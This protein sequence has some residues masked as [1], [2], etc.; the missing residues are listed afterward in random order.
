M[1]VFHNS[2]SRY[3]VVFYRVHVYQYLCGGQSRTGKKK[4]IRKKWKNSP[5]S[6]FFRMPVDVAIADETGPYAHGLG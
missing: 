1:E 2:S 5:R 3:M 6:F 4:K